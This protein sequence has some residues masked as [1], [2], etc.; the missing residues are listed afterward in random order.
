MK[1]STRLKPPP[2]YRRAGSKTRRD[3]TYR[4]PIEILTAGKSKSQF[5][6]KGFRR[7]QNEWYAQ[8]KATGF[9]DIEHSENSPFITDNHLRIRRRVRRGWRTG[10]EAMF[11]AATDYLSGAIASRRSE[12][13]H[14]ALFIT[15]MPP[16]KIAERLGVPLRGV[17]KHCYSLIAR[18]REHVK[19]AK[20]SEQQTEDGSQEEG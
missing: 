19:E 7:L 10:Q 4:H 6:T 18:A 3:H 20:E 2:R 12:R 13:I 5:M 14:A 15:G 1:Y 9:K 8:L 17:Q 11:A 16:A